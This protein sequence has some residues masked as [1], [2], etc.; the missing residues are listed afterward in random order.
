MSGA[1]TLEEAWFHVRVSA[2]QFNLLGAR[3]EG[4]S[5]FE[6]YSIA[7]S[8]QEYWEVAVPFAEGQFLRL[9]YPQSS[10]Q[11]FLPS[12][13]ALVVAKHLRRLTAIPA[14]APATVRVMAKKPASRSAVTSS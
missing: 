7:F 11:D 13:L 4:E 9:Y 2:S 1:S 12:S 6:T 3:L 14:P 5:R 8:G 10:P